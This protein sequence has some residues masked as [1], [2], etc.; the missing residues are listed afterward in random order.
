[1]RPAGIP[2]CALTDS[3]TDASEGTGEQSAPSQPAEINPLL[4][5]SEQP[6]DTGEQESSLLEQIE[7]DS[8]LGD[9][10]S[11]LTLEQFVQE[12]PLLGILQPNVTRQGQFVPGAGVGFAHI[13]TSRAIGPPWADLYLETG[14]VFP[15]PGQ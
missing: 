5:E 9:T 10:T 14:S 13:R 1:M 15:I 2:G 12:N 8:L 7:A 11:A 6:A 3:G 4:A